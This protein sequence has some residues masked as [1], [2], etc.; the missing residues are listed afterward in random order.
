MN[1]TALWPMFIGSIVIGLFFHG[2]TVL[3]YRVDDFYIS[4]GLVYSAVLMAAS[5]CVLEVVIMGYSSKHLD[6]PHLVGFTV[7]TILMIVVIRKQIGIRD[8]DYLQEM[9]THH[10]AALTTSRHIAERTQITDVLVLARNIIK[11]Q[12]REIALMKD[13]LVTA[14]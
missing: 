12:E 13:L 10:S 4:K 8:R 3:T 14:D 9:I 1:T 5:M 7:L 6:I 11:T 2:M